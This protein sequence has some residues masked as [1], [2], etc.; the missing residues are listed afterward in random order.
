[1]HQPPTTL[2]VATSTQVMPPGRLRAP[3]DGGLLFADRFQNGTGCQM[4]SSGDAGLAQDEGV[5]DGAGLC[6]G[7]VGLLERMLRWCVRWLL[8]ETAR[9]AKAHP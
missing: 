7:H 6:D 2:P 1:M 9:P 8:S 4:V 5:N 3:G